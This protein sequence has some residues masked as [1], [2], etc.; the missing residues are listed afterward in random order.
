MSTKALGLLWWMMMMLFVSAKVLNK[1]GKNDE[2]KKAYAYAWHLK[3]RYEFH[4]GCY[5]ESIQAC[6]KAIELK[7][8]NATFWLSKSRIL[9]AAGRTTEADAALSKAKEL[10]YTG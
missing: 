2:A 1:L 4:F 10:G 8:Q 5:D 3:G 7:P 9:S 6:D